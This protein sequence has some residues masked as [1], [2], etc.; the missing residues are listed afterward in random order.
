[1]AVQNL[2]RLGA[3]IEEEL[4]YW[5]SYLSTLSKDHQQYEA[6]TAEAAT[7]SSRRQAMQHILETL[8]LRHKALAS[9]YNDGSIEDVELPPSCSALLEQLK[10]EAGVMDLGDY[11][12]YKMFKGKRFRQDVLSHEAEVGELEQARLEVL[13]GLM[14]TFEMLKI[15]EGENMLQ[16]DAV[17]CLVKTMDEAGLSA[18]SAVAKGGNSR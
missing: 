6:I 8:P 3:I 2:G 17:Q 1:M 5:M 4:M 14:A 16:C 15:L 10:D 18:N 13:K 12:D 9:A 7:P 11:Y